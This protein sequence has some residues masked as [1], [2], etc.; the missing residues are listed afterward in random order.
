MKQP[1]PKPKPDPPDR[2]NE[3]CAFC[4]SRPTTPTVVGPV[5]SQVTVYLCDGCDAC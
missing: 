3:P 4:G 2:S 1:E 5:G